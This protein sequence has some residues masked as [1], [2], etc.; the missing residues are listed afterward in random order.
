MVRGNEETHSP[1]C[2]DV[3]STTPTPITIRWPNKQAKLL[4]GHEMT[5]EC[6]KTSLLRKMTAIDRS[7]YAVADFVHRLF[8]PD[9]RT[10]VLFVSV[11][12]LTVRAECP[13]AEF[14]SSL[15]PQVGC[16]GQAGRMGHI[17]FLKKVLQCSAHD[18]DSVQVAWPQRRSQV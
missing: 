11:A 2:L 5:S 9:I 6:H 8:G 18:A 15:Q 10:R 17:I 4:M 1:M 3:R 14:L 7:V 16:W 13:V 12:I